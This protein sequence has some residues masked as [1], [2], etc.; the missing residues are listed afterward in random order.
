[1]F[2]LAYAAVRLLLVGLYVR[3]RLHVGELGRKLT[4]IYIAVFGFTAALWLVSTLLPEPYRIILWGV[5]LAID[6]CSPP[7]AWGG[8]PGSTIVVSHITERF[9][10]FFIVVLGLSVAAVVAA[11]AG[12]Q[13]T[14]QA[15]VIAVA[16]FI[17]ALCLWWIYFDLADTSVVGR[18]VLGLVF[19]YAHFL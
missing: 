15:I 7:F 11:V 8:L 2:A 3:A 17:T 18:G 5:A 16:C 1:G 12:L 13:F 19:P 10:T 6:L 14:T 4:D 9:G